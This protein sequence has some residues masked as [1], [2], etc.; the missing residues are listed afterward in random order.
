MNKIFRLHN[1]GSETVEDW[2]ET[3]AI[4][5]VHINTIPD[6][7][8]AKVSHEI[9]AIPTPFARIDIATNAYRQVNTLGQP[10]GTTIYHKVV[11][12]CLDVLELFFQAPLLGNTVEIIPWNSG[13]RMQGN[14]LTIDPYSDLGQLLGTQASAPQRLFGQTL[15]MFLQQDAQAY[16]FNELQQLYLL[17]YANGPHPLNII[18]G[19]SPATLTFSS[20]NDLSFVN[21]SLGD[22][23]AF[24]GPP[25]ALNRR[26]EDFI[27]YVFALRESIRGFNQKFPEVNEYLNNTIF[28]RLPEVLQQKVRALNEGSYAEAYTNI[29]IATTGAGS[30]PE[31]LS[32]PLRGIAGLEE[33]IAGSDFT[34]K[35]GTGKAISGKM[36][37]VLPAYSF[38]KP[39]NYVGGPWSAETRVPTAD[40]NPLE[41]RRLPGMEQVVHPYLTV[42]DFLEDY[43]LRL[44]FSTDGSLFFNGHLNEE[45]GYILPLK[46]E[47]FRYF[48]AEDIQGVVPGTGVKMF[49]MKKGVAGSVDVALRLPVQK[50][51]F[52]ELKRTYKVSQS[53]E[54]P[55]EPSAIENK[56]VVSEHA[57]TVAVYP[58]LKTGNDTG[59]NYRILL[60]DA[61]K[62]LHN[63]HLRYG[64]KFFKDDA[65]VSEV[66]AEAV[67]RKQD[68]SEGYFSTDIYALNREFD[69]IEVSSNLPASGL[70]IPRLRKVQEGLQPFTFAVDFGTTNT[71]VAYNTAGNT[72]PQS[73][74]MGGQDRQL[75][76]LHV[77]D[78]ANF[79]RLA[80]ARRGFAVLLKVHESDLLPE[81]I[82]NAGYHFPHRTVLA[83]SLRI[84][85][86]DTARALAGNNISFTYEL[87]DTSIYQESITNLKWAKNDPGGRSRTRIGTFIEEV[88]MLIRN[89]ILLNGG[90]VDTARIVWFYPSSMTVAE[91]GRLESIWGETVRKYLSP[92]TRLENLSE[93][94]A[95]FYDYKNSGLIVGNSQ[96]INIDIG[97][98]T[99]DIVL[100]KG[101]NP[102]DSTSFRFAG[103]AIFGDGYG[104]SAKDNGF[105]QAFENA[106]L[107]RVLDDP[108]LQGPFPA[109]Y[110]SLK[111]KQ[112]SDDVI[113]FLFTLQRHPEYQHLGVSLTRFLQE[114]AQLKVVPLLAFAALIY[115]TASWMK[116]QGYEHPQRITFSG[117]GSR[118]L[119][120]LDESLHPQFRNLALFV[121]L[122]FST[123]YGTAISGLE[124]RR[125]E[126]PKEVT[127]RG[128]LY[129]AGEGIITD[130]SRS[131]LST[132]GA[133]VAP[134]QTLKYADL[135]ERAIQQSAAAETL[136]FLNLFQ[137]WNQQ[138]KFRDVFGADMSVYIDYLA[139]VQGKL[140]TYLEE[141][142]NRK[143][144]E[145]TTEPGEELHETLFFLPLIPMLHE[146]AYQIS[147]KSI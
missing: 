14:E 125:A 28:T 116:S 121:N 114:H 54:V 110:D 20:G 71:Y 126:N 38:P 76:L 128:G 72:A 12:D 60:A 66:A 77:D 74:T 2:Q 142:I 127:A 136:Q 96:S 111:K 91:R 86:T 31:I 3:M 23:K 112:S 113:S 25:R 109:I 1:N 147:Q 42:S 81:V 122:I 39:L 134:G 73:L 41:N 78:P 139:A 100:F 26:S 51:H 7:A 104:G 29:D 82:G 36:P 50:G 58:F 65:S 119:D 10:D 131:I 124:L 98:G 44:P 63:Q 40:P 46:K 64:L 90:S 129:R 61:D 55:L 83:E 79:N 145:G 132:A 69:L 120:I 133:A 88:V 75:G 48:S 32:Y 53:L 15:R 19:T 59:A 49:E 33:Q 4:Q 21:I 141:G 123:V 102:M 137:A 105:V 101:E 80:Q 68:K 115:H 47:V 87:R 117:S 67:Q 9:T 8:G 93:S 37:L 16:N 27:L 146:L 84:G 103:N 43:L 107:R 99:T 138:L 94:V 135:N 35:P 6:P 143:Q 144:K 85:R 70:L 92:K 57:V 22:R 13:I 18:G 34:L 45:T 89:K 5:N 130:V 11:S 95:P 24:A 97:G 118:F 108:N 62:E 30:H 56:G 140:P 17:N 52:I 106:Q